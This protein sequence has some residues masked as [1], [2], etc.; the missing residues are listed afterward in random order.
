MFSFLKVC[1]SHQKSCFLFFC[2]I[3]IEIGVSQDG[4]LE[5]CDFIFLFISYFFPQ[6]IYVVKIFIAECLPDL[7]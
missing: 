1:Q 7:V 5:I 6:N 4:T 2:R 3:V